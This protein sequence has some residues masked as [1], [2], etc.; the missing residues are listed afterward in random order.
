MRSNEILK[1]TGYWNP[2]KP[3]RRV[4]FAML[5]F[6]VFAT[7]D[8]QFSQ[9]LQVLLYGGTCMFLEA[10]VCLCWECR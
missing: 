8:I 9:Q 3:K 2:Q 10:N 7:R 5:S 1:M 6:C 4:I